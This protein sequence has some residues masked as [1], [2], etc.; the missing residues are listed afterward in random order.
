[1]SQTN[2]LGELGPNLSCWQRKTVLFAEASCF[3]MLSLHHSDALYLLCY[4]ILLS[5]Y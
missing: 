1:M 3:L 5:C 2:E 4:F